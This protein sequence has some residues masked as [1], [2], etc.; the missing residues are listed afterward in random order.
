MFRGL[1][2]DYGKCPSKKET[3]FG[4]KVHVTITL[5]GYVP[6]FE[7]TPAST[8]DREGLCDMV[9]EQSG[10]VMLGDKDYTG[11]PWSKNYQDKECALWH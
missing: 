7:V 3:Y 5:E 2:A 11:K 1:G 6:A 9:D 10:I 8:D 4:Y